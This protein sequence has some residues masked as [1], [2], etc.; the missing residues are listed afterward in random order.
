MSIT[1]NSTGIRTDLVA[2]LRGKTPAEQR[3]FDSR[4]TAFEPEELPAICVF[5]AGGA[6]DKWSKNTLLNRHTERVQ[7]T[8][9]VT[10]TD[11][12]ALGAALDTMADA[13]IDN[14]MGDPEW[15]S[16]FESIESVKVEKWQPDKDSKFTLLAVTC[17]FEVRYA[18]QY[19]PTSQA[20]FKTAAVTT[21]SADPAGAD[22]SLRTIELAQ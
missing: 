17:T 6:E 9:F 3:V 19:V 12:A 11:E 18:V 14:L 8:S 7:V 1:L 5:S 22:V 20:P 15:A 4:L 13:V 21:T 2:R 10:E 16:A